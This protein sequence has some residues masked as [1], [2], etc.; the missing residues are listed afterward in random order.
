MSK[1]SSSPPVARVKV[2]PRGASRL[3]NGHVW[4]YRSDIVAA[5]GATP[6]SVV[7]VT[8]HRGQVLGAA[9]YSSSSQIAIRLISREPVDDFPALL[10]QRI[11]D[12][13]A[14]REPLLHD[15]NAYRIIFSEADFLPGLIVDRY[16]DILSMQILTQAMDAEIV[17]ETLLTELT[18]K[19]R[20][21]SVVERAD[22]RVRQLEELPPRPSGLLQGEKASTIFSMN[23]IQFHFAALEGQKTGAFLD[24][25]E[26]YAAAAQYAHGEA[27]DVFC[28]QGGFALHLAP[29][30]SHVIGVDGSRPALEVA[31]ENAALN[32]REIEWI[33]ASAFDLLKDYSSLGQRYDTIVLDPPA[34]AKTKR[35]LDAAMRG[36]KELNLRA[37]K[38]LRPGGTL[39]TCSCSYH[40]SQADFLEMLAGSARD[41]HR[42]LRLVEV[43]GQARD[44]PV[45][46]NIA[47]TAYLKCIIATV[48]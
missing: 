41:A 23:S 26:N 11:A 45:L 8:D 40:V 36:Y 44:H 47:E 7:N 46:L 1:V 35:D 16:N 32:R 39:V 24:Q 34:F 27:L 6:G 33:E 12:A 31:D 38:M 4:V 25:R 29:Q 21:A 2:S 43:R 19:L 37:L 14:Y 3:K 17:R 18:N 5:N 15:T 42:T 10:R 13:I 22:P 20:P 48:S 30:C 28:Y 9:L